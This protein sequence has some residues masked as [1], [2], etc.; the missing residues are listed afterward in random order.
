MPFPVIGITGHVAD[1]IRPRDA[2]LFAVRSTY[3]SAVE[4]SRGAALIIPPHLE[5]PGLRAVYECLNAIILSGGGDMHPS[6]YGEDD[7]GLPRQVDVERDRAEITLARWAIEEGLPLLA[8]CRGAQVLNVAAG[9]T[10]TQDIPSQ[11]PDA[12]FH[13]A[14]TGRAP[15]CVAHSVDVFDASRLALLFG[16]GKMGVNSS[17]HQAAKAVGDR[18]AVTARAADGVIEGLEMA[19][20]PFC[21]GVQWHPESMIRAHPQMRRVFDALVEAALG[22]L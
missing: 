15:E 18:L 22:R 9:G 4:Q 20:H 8:I 11:V 16:G 7:C 5:R 3:V 12:L 1:S 21:L 2:S 14:I 6:S 17:H 19:D 13:S 10:L